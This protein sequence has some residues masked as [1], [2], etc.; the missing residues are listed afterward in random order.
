MP[1]KLYAARA[2]LHF[3]EEP[4]ISGNRGSGTVF[5]SGCTLRCV[6]C[7]N[8]SIA[9]GD[10][11]QEISQERLTEM[12]QGLPIC[13]ACFSGAY[14]IQPPEEDIRGEYVQ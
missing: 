1:A 14:P 13:T 8:R 4:C 10:A 2:A 5:F 9:R 12:A 3:W 6:Y 7:Q 11:G